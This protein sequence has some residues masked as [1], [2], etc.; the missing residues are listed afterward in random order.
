MS[1]KDRIKGLL[2]KYTTWEH[3]IS[4]ALI[5]AL[6]LN[7][8]M[9]EDIQNFIPL[10]YRALGIFLWAVSGLIVRGMQK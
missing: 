8:S 1:I 7:Q 9:P 6:V 3:M 5:S 10:K 4:S 2:T